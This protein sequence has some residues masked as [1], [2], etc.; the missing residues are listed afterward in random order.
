L[1]RAKAV[2]VVELYPRRAQVYWVRVPDEPGGK[3]RPALVVSP[4]VRNRLANDVIV[5]PIS[6]ALREAPT[7]V[8]LRAH[9]GGLHRASVVKC[10]QITTLGRN[11]LLPRPLGGALSSARMVE[12]EKAILRS[13]GVPVS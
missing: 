1:G 12:I 2:T 6:S 7:H 3:R 5:V 10:E 9:E 8:R 11:R 4:D 13:I